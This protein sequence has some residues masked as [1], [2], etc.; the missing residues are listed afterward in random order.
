MANIVTEYTIIGIKIPYKEMEK[1]ALNIISEGYEYIWWQND[2]KEESLFNDYV[3]F[4]TYE[5]DGFII[6]LIIDNRIIR[7]RHTEEKLKYLPL[8]QEKEKFDNIITMFNEK[9]NLDLNKNEYEVFRVA[10]ES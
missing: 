4:P 3:L 9:Y 5:E 7:N 6:G 10:R 1:I 2:I 8:K